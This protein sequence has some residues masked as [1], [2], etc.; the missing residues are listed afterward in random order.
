MLTAMFV[1]LI[2]VAIG[3]PFAG[4][5]LRQ[6][7]LRSGA[8]QLASDLR[9][10]RQRAVT[11]H[12]PLRVC[13]SGCVLAVP[14]GAY[15]VEIDQGTTSTP[16]WASETGTPSRLPEDV[17]VSGTATATFASTG[18]ASGGTFTL[19]NTAGIYQVAVRSTGQVVTCKGSCP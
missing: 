15:S 18:M 16:S 14:A 9:L 4:S 6:L 8:W 11:L 2:V 3:M 19:T 17:G 5:V 7:R 10:A 13:I 12:T 1:V